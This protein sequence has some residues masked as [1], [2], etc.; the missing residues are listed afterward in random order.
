MRKRRNRKRKVQR[1]RGS[2][3]GGRQ[4][5]FI[6]STLNTHQQIELKFFQKEKDVP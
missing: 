3:N 4:G 6:K 1:E 2:A 5:V